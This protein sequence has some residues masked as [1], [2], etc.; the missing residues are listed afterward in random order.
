MPSTI[1]TRGEDNQQANRS[2]RAFM[3]TG[4]LAQAIGSAGKVAGLARTWVAMATAEPDSMDQHGRL[5]SHTLTQSVAL[6]ISFSTC[7]CSTKMQIVIATWRLPPVIRF[8]PPFVSRFPSFD[9]II[10]IS[11]PFPCKSQLERT[12]WFQKNKGG[13]NNA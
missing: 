2:H 12:K 11:L 6:S 10:R 4:N 3:K 13:A 5:Y 8:Y 9:K 1:V 7:I